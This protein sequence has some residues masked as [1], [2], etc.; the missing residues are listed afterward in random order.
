[1]RHPLIKEPLLVYR[2]DK[3]K[4]EHYTTYGQS[5]QMLAAYLVSRAQT[6]QGNAQGEQ[7]RAEAL[8]LPGSDSS[9]PW[10]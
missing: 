9:P 3:A 2:T 10:V 5:S 8:A 1:M 4:R 6:S 7:R